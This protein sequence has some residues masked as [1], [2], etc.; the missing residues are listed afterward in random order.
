MALGAANGMPV[1]KA[2]AKKYFR[3]IDRQLFGMGRFSGSSL[4]RLGLAEAVASRRDWREPI[5]PVPVQPRGPAYPVQ[6]GKATTTD[7]S[8]PFAT[9]WNTR[10]GCGNIR[11]PLSSFVRHWP[12]PT[13]GGGISSNCTPTTVD[14]AKWPP[15]YVLQR[16]ADAI[17]TRTLR[18]K[19]N[20]TSA[21]ARTQADRNLTARPGVGP[22][23]NW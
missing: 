14:R 10:P 7:C 16:W 18:R 8:G 3:I 4:T 12:P 22:I 9:D 20:S 1:A 19:R 17:P 15:T 23:H 13:P 6:R 2:T 5:S 11:Q 21:T